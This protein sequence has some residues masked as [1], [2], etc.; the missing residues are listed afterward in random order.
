MAWIEPKVDWTSSDCYNVADVNRVEENTMTI[1]DH[2][3]TYNNRPLVTTDT[4][5]NSVKMLFAADFNR[6]ESNIV[7]LRDALYTP[8]NWIVPKTNWLTLDKFDYI[9]ANRLES[10]LSGLYTV[11]INILAYV[12]YCGSEQAVCGQDNSDL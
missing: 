4:T 6:I 7:K 10:N 5:W 8:P 9:D 11:S 1:A 2:I 3:E 12:M